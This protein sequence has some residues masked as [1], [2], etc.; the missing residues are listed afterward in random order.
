MHLLWKVV[1]EAYVKICVVGEYSIVK[2]REF[3]SK[4]M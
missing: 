3:D 4:A 1:L 2:S